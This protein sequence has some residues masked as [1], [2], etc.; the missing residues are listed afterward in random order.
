V[1]A[2]FD[3]PVQRYHVTPRYLAGATFTSDLALRP[4]LEVG[5]PRHRDGEGNLHLSSPDQ[6][7]RIGYLGETSDTAWKIAAFSDSY[8]DLHWLATFTSSTPDEIVAGFLGAVAEGYYDHR[9]ALFCGPGEVD[10]AYAPLMEARW[11]RLV[12]ERAIEFAAPDGWAALRYQRRL[13]ERA[14]W[15]DRWIAWGG[16]DGWSS[17]WHA[18]ATPHTPTH[19]IAATATAMANPAPVV[20][21]AEQ[22]P[23]NS[24]HLV[25][26]TPLP[27]PRTGARTEAARARTTTSAPA[28]VTGPAPSTPPP[29]AG[30]TPLPRRR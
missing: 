25:Q 9:D 23:H 7:V 8:R 3:D 21:T 16:P 30:P 22:I 19:L 2:P 6:R 4:L 18:T 24:R 15:P 27:P 14:Q 28:P 5:W 11:G 10:H 12:N 1:T 26:T 20:R 13:P 17:R 29:A